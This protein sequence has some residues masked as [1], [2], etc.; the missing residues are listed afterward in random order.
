MRIG[1][2]IQ[3]YGVEVAGGAELHCRWV[4]E[5]LAAHHEVEVITTTAIEYLTWENDYPTGM[6]NVNGVPVRRFHVER[7]RDEESFQRLS[8]QVCFHRHPD[9]DERAWVEEHGPVA[10][11]L[12][13][14]LRAHHGDYDALVFF[15]YRY[16]TSFHGITIAPAKSILVPTAEHD[17]AIHLRIFKRFFS[18]PARILYNSPE[19]KK[20][21]HDISATPPAQGPVVG[22]GISLERKV[23]TEVMRTRLDLLGDYIIYVGRIEREKGCLR[24][25]D[26]FLRYIG[27]VNPTLNLVLAGKSALTIEEHV[28]I[29]PMGVVT[30]DE[31]F[32]AVAAARAL[33]MPS[34][35]ESLSMVLL[36][37][38]LM[39][40]P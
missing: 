12:T 4:V 7:K 5:R 34:P 16:W 27:E 39:K 35:Y 40:R 19:E 8:N 23:D 21:I 2:V 3:R 37:A 25:I 29:I 14:Y 20:L 11:Q 36:E 22:V 17:R 32:A 15:C 31:K 38:W 18:I 9:R 10:P 30:E 6:E 24:L 33:I 28:N 13:D 1:F 26:F